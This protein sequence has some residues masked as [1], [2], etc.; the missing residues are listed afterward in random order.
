MARLFDF[1]KTVL[2]AALFR[3]K[4]HCAWCGEDLQELIFHGHHVVPNQAATTHSPANAWL[5][6]EENCVMLC[7][8]C[9]RVFGHEDGRYRTGAVPFARNYR[10]SH[11]GDHQAHLQWASQVDSRPWPR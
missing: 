11:A 1:S 6:T 2:D 7:D 10:F 5:R 9:H 3:Q 8:N 4:F